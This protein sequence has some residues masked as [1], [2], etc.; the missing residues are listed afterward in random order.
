MDRKRMTQIGHA[1]PYNA[2]PVSKDART[3]VGK[4]LFNSTAF[5]IA[6]VCSVLLDVRSI[7]LLRGILRRLMFQ[8]IILKRIGAVFRPLI[9]AIGWWHRRHMTRHGASF[10]INVWPIFGNQT[11]AWETDLKRVHS[12]IYILLYILLFQQGFKLLSILAS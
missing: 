1:Y 5:E 4:L 6:L 10:Q 8:W 2:Y 7:T 9:A 12:L 3:Q 11:A